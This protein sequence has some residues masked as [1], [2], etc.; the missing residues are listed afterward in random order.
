MP[1]NWKSNACSKSISDIVS[2]DLYRLVAWVSIENSLSN[3]CISH[4]KRNITALQELSDADFSWGQVR[5]MPCQSSVSIP[6]AHVKSQGH[7]NI[8]KAA[9]KSSWTA[10]SSIVVIPY[11]GNSC[12]NRAIKGLM[13]LFIGVPVFWVLDLQVGVLKYTAYKVNL[14]VLFKS[15]EIS[16]LRRALH[17][18]RAC[19]VMWDCQF[20]HI[21]SVFRWLAYTSCFCILSTDCHWPEEV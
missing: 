18:D 2:T 4:T 3:S 15:S 7:V 9:G 6:I 17:D 12:W 14:Q 11:S 13:L 8:N 19:T 20:L 1:S 16:H 21:T 5:K 10:S